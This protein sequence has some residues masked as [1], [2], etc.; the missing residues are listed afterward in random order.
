VN[1]RIPRGYDR[2]VHESVATIAESNEIFRDVVCWITVFMM[3]GE[4]VPRSADT[5]GMMVAIKDGLP[6]LL[7]SGEAVF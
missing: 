2:R 7:P 1:L 3:N 5:A 6:G 4:E